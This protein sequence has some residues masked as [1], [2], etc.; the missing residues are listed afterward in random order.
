MAAVRPTGEWIC[1]TGNLRRQRKEGDL[2]F[3][4][5]LRYDTLAFGAINV[6]HEFPDILSVHVDV[7][8]VQSNCP[9]RHSTGFYQIQRGFV[10]RTVLHLSRDQRTVRVRPHAGHREEERTNLGTER[11]TTNVRPSSS[12][13]QLQ[14]GVSSDSG[15]TGSGF[16]LKP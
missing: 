12:T 7:Q 10:D 16:S 2:D 5:S 4:L 8:S 1:V 13:L 3:N 15:V 14:L 11:V 6:K 9:E